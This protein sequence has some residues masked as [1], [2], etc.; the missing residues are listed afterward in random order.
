MPFGIVGLPMYTFVF[1]FVN[2]LLPNRGDWSF[3]WFGVKIITR[4]KPSGRQPKSAPRDGGG[5]GNPLDARPMYLGD[6]A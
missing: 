2:L 5:L 6:T 1:V 4:K 3:I